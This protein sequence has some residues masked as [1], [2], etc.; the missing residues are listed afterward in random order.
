MNTKEE[1]VNCLKNFF[2]KKAQQYGLEMVFLYG[3]WARGFPKEDS[4]VDIAIV[5]TKENGA[6][7]ELFCYLNDIS[8]SLSRELGREVNG[9][10]I[11]SDFNKPM[12]YYNAIV[13]GI[14]VFIKDSDKYICLR[15][16]AVFQMED[17]NLFGIDWQ[18]RI[19]RKNLEELKHG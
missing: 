13:L 11:Q 2:N 17:F 4:D 15:N 7:D 12:L 18:V 16:E 19:T 9:I 1:I 6:D 10:A 5:F 3:S 8:L 14:P